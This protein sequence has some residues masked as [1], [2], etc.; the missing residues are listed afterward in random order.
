MKTQTPQVHQA[1][2]M[3]FLRDLLVNGDGV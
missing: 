1:R 3:S 2:K